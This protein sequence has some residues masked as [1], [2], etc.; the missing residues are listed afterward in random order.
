MIEHIKKI[1][2]NILI[3]SVI[4][5]IVILMTDFVW[6]I[7]GNKYFTAGFAFPLIIFFSFVSQRLFL[8]RKVEVKLEIFEKAEEVKSIDEEC[9]SRKLF[10]DELLDYVLT[11][12]EIRLTSNSNNFEVS[13]SN[14]FAVGSMFVQFPYHNKYGIGE[15]VIRT[16]KGEYPCAKYERIAIITCPIRKKLFFDIYIKLLAEAETKFFIDKR[17]EILNQIQLCLGTAEES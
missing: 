5:F 13:C 9:Q 14:A 1:G 7:T 3:I 11:N 17:K 10:N 12:S 6:N 16:K 2:I 4:A 15:M 8:I